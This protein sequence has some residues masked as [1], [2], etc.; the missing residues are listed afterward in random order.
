MTAIAC[1]S[2]DVTQNTIPSLFN[3]APGA[4]TVPIRAGAIAT[5]YHW[6]S[7]GGVVAADAVS[8]T[9]AYVR[10]YFGKLALDHM[11]RH[12]LT[13]APN[14]QIPLT[15]RTHANHAG[16][17]TIPLADVL[18]RKKAMCLGAIRA[19]II[20]MWN[21][22][23]ANLIPAELSLVNVLR[24]NN[25]NIETLVVATN[26][27]MTYA[28]SCAFGMVDFTQDESDVMYALFQ[29]SMAVL[30]LAGLSILSTGHHY[31]SSNGA[32][33]EAVMKQVMTTSSE[34][35]KAW[36]AA[37]TAVLKDMIWH[38]S[39]HPVTSAHLVAQA[40]SANVAT[41]L[42]EAQMGSASVRLPY[43]EPEMKAAKAMVALVANVQQPILQVDAV[44][45]I[46]SVVAAIAMV[47]RF[48][49]RAVALAVAPIAAYPNVFDRIGA[50]NHILTPAVAGAAV[51]V[52][53]ALG[54]CGAML[55]SL[56]V[57]DRHSTLMNAKSLERVK[58]EQ[59]PAVTAGAAFYDNLMK[60]DRRNAEQGEINGP[61]MSI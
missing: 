8:Y 34:A 1:R 7:I 38:K 9:K 10:V 44:L 11:V 3:G 48:Q 60:R 5:C 4:A 39:A 49:V 2:M 30:P 47:N 15:A 61:N 36:F 14:A 55:E 50:I 57:R 46:P 54:V 16:A 21:A 18:L 20:S 35:V 43:I 22:D 37:D 29:M 58:H 24:L 27:A 28:E 23:P 32:A 6:T 40:L 33:T 45:E 31:L 59:L 26:A 17:R 52:G 53:Y 51:A 25:G 42:K 41:R 12:N 19:G 13:L 56:P